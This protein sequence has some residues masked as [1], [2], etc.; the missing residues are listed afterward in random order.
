MNRTIALEADGVALWLAFRDDTLPEVVHWGA[1]MP[2]SASDL[3]EAMTAV[4]PIRA[5]NGMDAPVRVSVLPEG[6]M[7]FP[8]RPGVEGHRAGRSWSPLW[9]TDTVTVDGVEV[10]EHHEGAAGS[11][12]VSATDADAALGLAL[13]V[14]LLPGGLVRTRATLTNLG[15]EPYTVVSVTPRLP[16]PQRATELLDF[17]GHW[18]T[19]RTPQQLPFAIGSHVR[20]GRHGRTGADAATV[21]HAGERG[22]GF[23]S[24]E[25]WG[26]HV[27]WSGNHLHVAERLSSG[28][29]LGGGEL[30][31]PGEV[32]LAT[33]ESY[34]SP[35]LYGSY[36]TGLDAL[37]HHFH[38]FL[39]SRSDYPRSPRPVT[40]NSWEATYFDHDLDGLF[41]LVDL[42]A[43]VG[44]ERFVLDDGWFGSRRGDNRGLGDWWVSPDVYPDGLHPLVD[45]VTGQGMQFG[46]WFEPEM[47]NPDS[48]VARAHPEWMLQVP[49]RMPPESRRQQV[50]DF[51]NPDCY[52]YVRDAMARMLDEYAI[53]YIKWDHN[54][55]LV[56]AGSTAHEGRP[57]VHDQTLATYRLMR[58]LKAHKPGLEIESCSSGGGRVDL[59]VMDICDR[60][61]GS[62]DTDS[63][64][65]LRIQRWTM[66]LLPPE[67][68]G[69][70]IGSTPS[71]QTGRRHSVAFRAATALVGHLGVEW[72]LR[73]V[74]TDELAE[75]RG[76]LALY[77]GVRSL[78]HSGEVVRG[79]EPD[80]WLTGVVSPDRT[81]A[82][83]VLVATEQATLDASYGRIRLTGLDPSKR[84]AVRPIVVP[85]V[86]RQSGNSASW[87]GTGDG[88]ELSGLTVS[89]AWLADEGLAV[90]GLWPDSPMVL[91]VREV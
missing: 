57:A 87:F 49:G 3:A 64:E 13:D 32:V 24:G 40:L 7:G 20:E 43:E 72:D 74:G 88:T 89:G 9:R 77:K 91:L 60:V 21:L 6:R 54:R 34:A 53:S 47:V 84:Y 83:Y 37:A 70:H 58:E 71:H 26:V 82:M 45:R 18:G 33:G 16:V 11:V 4:E 2:R 27:A 51:T 44:V 48:E 62:D 28:R 12:R 10:G 79:D 19:E 90:P 73:A 29:W 86:T 50:M 8:G 85:E 76:W 69:N 68:I 46:L 22:F 25:V 14:E 67:L 80:L 5:D 63:V 66:Q 41:R 23:A 61:W 59:A 52:A 31:L 65:R 35:W 75:L 39:R 1:P 78:L 56:D 55:D 30:L 38:R 15:D 17:A 36:G 81:R 42:A